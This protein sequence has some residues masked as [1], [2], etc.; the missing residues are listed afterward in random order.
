MHIRPLGNRLLVRPIDAP[1]SRVVF[2]P[3]ETSRQTHERPGTDATAHTRGVVVA[4]GPGARTR[5]GHRP[6]AAAVGD[7]LR[8]SDS[9][10]R[11][12]WAT[13]EKLLFIREDDIVGIEPE[14]TEQ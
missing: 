6:I 3:G 4:V 1:R 14:G 9:C 10:G 2:V 5:G 12:T 7:V 8:F 11:P 13:G